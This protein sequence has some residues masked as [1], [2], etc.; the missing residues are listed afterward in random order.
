MRK[1]NYPGLP[2]HPQHA[3][4]TRFF[5]GGYGGMLSFEL[6]GTAADADH[7]MHALKL[8]ACAPSLG[9]VETLVTRPA[10]TS[11]CG[12]SAEERCKVGISDGLI[13]VSVGIEAADDLVADFTQALRA[14]TAV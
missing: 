9:G 3:L 2:D 12:M 10:T 8:A 7:L 1:V 11:H 14:R 5:N 4:A 13:R 6:D